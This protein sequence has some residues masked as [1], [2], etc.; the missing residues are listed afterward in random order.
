MTLK[1]GDRFTVYDAM[2]AAD[3]FS[4]NPANSNSRNKDG[5]ALYTGPVKFPMMLY[6]PRGE[7]RVLVPGTKERTPYGTVEIFGEQWEIISKV[8]ANETELADA[9]AEGW[10]KHPA[11]AIKAANETWRKEQGLRPLPVPAVSA[12]SLISELEE[13]NRVLT[14]M[15]E[16]AK[17]NQS[18]LD[19]TE[20]RFVPPSKAASAV[21]K[22]GLV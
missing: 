4:A 20:A 12:G 13:K 15:L 21:A 17:R 22:A 5:Q 10:H 11:H 1:N 19:E 3:Y 8:V 7:E 2:E 9:I 16:E 14:E 6:H 18:T